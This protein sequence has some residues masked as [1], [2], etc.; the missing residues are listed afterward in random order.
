MEQWDIIRLHRVKAKD[1]KGSLLLT[2]S[3]GWSWASWKGN[4]RATKLIV[5]NNSFSL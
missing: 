4:V 2:S 5:P 1:F 3:K